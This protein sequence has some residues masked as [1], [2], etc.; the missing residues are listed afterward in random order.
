M[1]TDE[2]HLDLDAAS[3]RN[4]PSVT[5]EATREFEGAAM[6]GGEKLKANGFFVNVVQ[7]PA[8]TQEP[9]ANPMV[10]VVED[11]PGTAG[12]IDAVLKK[13]GFST[14]VAS[15]LQGIVRGINAKPHPDMVLLDIMLPDANGFAVL[16]RLRRHPDLGRIPVVMLSSLSEPADVAKGLALG[17]TGYLSKPARPQALVRAIKTVLGLDGGGEFGQ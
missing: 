3:A 7:R 1:T 15:N 16:E 12:V 13:Q 10:L 2:Q 9:I 14:R 4:E 8:A 5:P 6:I 17:A 11:D